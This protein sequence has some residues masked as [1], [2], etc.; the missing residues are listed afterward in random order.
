MSELWSSVCMSP[1][2]STTCGL[3]A[4]ML[5]T[6]VAKYMRGYSPGLHLKKC[7]QVTMV[8]LR[9]NDMCI[10]VVNCTFEFH[11]PN[12]F[13]HP[14]CHFSCQTKMSPNPV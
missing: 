9:M 4:K 8:T 5:F 11:L 14:S 12:H 1:K 3:D 6:K 7:H 2:P 13:I 10:H